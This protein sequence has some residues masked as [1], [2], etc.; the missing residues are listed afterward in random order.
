[1]GPRL[2]SCCPVPGSDR[3][4]S[5]MTCFGD[6]MQRTPFR[7]LASTMASICIQSSPAFSR[8]IEHTP[9]RYPL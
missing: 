3:P 5:L 4:V 1:M 7:S 8:L 6:F 9:P 2:W